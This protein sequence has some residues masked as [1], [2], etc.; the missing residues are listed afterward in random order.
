RNPNAYSEYLRAFARQTVQGVWLTGIQISEG[1]E[2]LSLTGRAVR[3]D[4]VPVLIG[5]LRQEPVL[6]GRPLDALAIT[7][8]GSAGKDGRNSI[9]DFSVTSPAQPG[10]PQS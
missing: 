8:T 3:A 10:K 1:G 9:V 6:R 7:R 5:R 4:L 2:Q